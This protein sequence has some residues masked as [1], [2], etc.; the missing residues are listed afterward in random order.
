MIVNS[1]GMSRYS[2]ITFT[3]P[4][5]TSV[6]VQSRGN[7]PV[8]NWILANRL[9]RRRSLL[10]RFTSM[11]IF[12]PS[13]MVRPV[14]ELLLKK[15]H[16][17]LPSGTSRNVLVLFEFHLPSFPDVFRTS[18]EWLNAKMQFAIDVRNTGSIAFAPIRA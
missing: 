3:P 16:W 10:R 1:E 2:A 18:H 7:E 11:S 4:A 13:I 15:N 14:F 8:P 6:I 12:A 9:H 5:D 17:N